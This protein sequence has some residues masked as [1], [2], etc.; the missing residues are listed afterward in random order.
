VQQQKSQ[1]DKLSS[2]VLALV[3]TSKV[4]LIFK[5]GLNSGTFFFLQVF[6]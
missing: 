4:T 3:K 6:C 2:V 1:C 5:N